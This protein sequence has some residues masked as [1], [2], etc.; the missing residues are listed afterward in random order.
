MAI[1]QAGV[2]KSGNFWLYRILRSVIR[3]GGLEA[4]SFI[5]QHPIHALAKTW[6]LP[7]TD[8]A[9]IDTL[10][11]NQFQCVTLIWPIFRE[12]VQDVDR[13]IASC[14]HVWTHSHLS[15][16]ALTVLSRFDKV[17]YIIR[18]PR[19]IA[20]SMSKFAFTPYYMK[21]CPHGYKDP[22]QYLAERLP[23]LIKNWARHVSAYLRF[24]KQLDIHVVYYERLLMS[25][26]T[27]LRTLLEYLGIDMDQG[28]IAAVADDI[29]FETMQNQ[30]PDHV[31]KG[32]S[33][34]WV[35][36]ISEEQNRQVLEIAGSLLGYLN[37]PL[38]KDS[39]G[40]LM[41]TLPSDR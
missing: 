18:D 39:V 7:T 25:F 9:D 14:S 31:R 12:P 4:K 16:Y 37:Y 8:H 1:L 28:G 41:P 35:D 2:A 6:D 10:E 30:N 40:H 11:I 23:V 29:G 17:V 13:Y 27:D 15:E 22:D 33:G 34:Q 24:R 21:H 36:V 20:V 3:H 26:E 38:D 19:D 5:K 32:R